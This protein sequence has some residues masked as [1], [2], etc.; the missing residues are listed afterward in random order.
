MAPT[1]RV[2]VLVY[3]GPSATL[4]S[5]RHATWSLRRLL[6]PN[7]AVLTVTSDQILKEPWTSSCALLVFPGGADL[8]YCRTLNGEGNR[9]I[10]QYV[11]LGGRYLGLCAGGYYGCGRCEFEVGG[12]RGMEVVGDRELGFFP[13]T[14]R[15]LAFGGFVYHSE[16]G[17]KAA[18]VQVNKDALPAAGDTGL[19]ETF[20]TYY[21][22]GGVF[23]DAAKF[24]GKGVE[25]LASY[26]ENVAVETGEGS[27]A[28]VVYCKVGEG[29]A[30]LTGPHPEFSAVNLIPSE[31]SGHHDYASVVSALL[32]DDA[33]RIAFMKACLTKLGLQVSTDTNGAVPSLSRMHLSAA[34]P[35]EVGELV[36]A[37]HEAG[38]VTKGEDGQDMIKGENDTFVLEEGG[39]RLDMSEVGDPL[40]VAT[41]ADGPEKQELEADGIVDYNTIPKHLIAHDTALP[42]AKATPHFNHHAFFSALHNYAAK[43]PHDSD[44]TFGKTLLYGEVVTSTNTLLDKNPTLLSHLPTGFTVTATTQLAG[45]GR[46]G[47]VWVSPPGSLMFS[48][49]LRHPLALSTTAPVVFVQYL[50]ALAIVAG[51]QGYGADGRGGGKAYA[52]LPIRLKWPNDIYALDPTTAKGEEKYVKIGGILVNSSYAGGDYTCVAG[53][54]LNLS[55]AAPTT[56]LAALLQAAH[57][58]GNKSNNTSPPPPFTPEA[59]LASILTH[60]EAL[61]TRFCRTGFDA[62]FESLYY[63]HWLHTD[64]IVTLEAEGGAR[65]RIKGITRDWGLLVA[66]ELGWEDRPTGKR[67]RLQSDSNSFD[68]FRG[69]VGRKL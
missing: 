36:Q 23:V 59:L 6:G 67:W 38:I 60:F 61:Y 57:T 11:Q 48:T 1:K 64:Q 4:S 12:E 62:Y 22:G 14:C 44:H 26:T 52:Q 16:A 31:P 51:I 30:I 39:G 55:N 10:K 35:T 19:P 53:I 45:R 49:V 25:V 3:A 20:R 13:G 56:S 8:G 63:S 69:L 43:A 42:D 65:A 28:A 27:A 2:N 40:P 21:N 41:S 9:R 34:Q 7:Y 37:W 15:G 5:V 33:S 47:N 32:A 54:G 58:A 50:A 18:E 29:A 24:A 66:E 46:G 17:A 68:F